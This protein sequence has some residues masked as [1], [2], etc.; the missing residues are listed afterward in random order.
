[1]VL[2]GLN[3]EG[4]IRGAAGRP[5]PLAV[6]PNAHRDIAKGSEFLLLDQ[7]DQ[8][9][10]G[11]DLRL[12]VC[13]APRHLELRAGCS[14]RWLSMGYEIGVLSKNRQGDKKQKR[15]DHKA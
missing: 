5:N 12:G 3:R 1:M 8:C 4:Q 6:E 7:I 11:I 9:F 2:A 15:S 10:A 13:V 14:T